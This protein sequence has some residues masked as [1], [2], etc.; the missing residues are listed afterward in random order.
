MGVL[1]DIYQRTMTYDKTYLAIVIT[2][3]TII[4]TILNIK[5]YKQLLDIDISRKRTTIWFLLEAISIS[6]GKIMFP[7]SVYKIV[8]LVLFPIITNL[9]L[10]VK[11]EKCLVLQLI[12]YMAI[13]LIELLFAQSLSKVFGIDGYFEGMC[14]PAYRLIMVGIILISEYIIYRIIKWKNIVMNFPKVLSRKQKVTFLA[15]LDYW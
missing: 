5:M 11:M 6:F 7:P 1:E 14:I 15:Y 9:I 4:W 10:K 13:Y 3:Y 8:N 2:F 12:D